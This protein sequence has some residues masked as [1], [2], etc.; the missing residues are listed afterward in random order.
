MQKSVY[1]A[2]QKLCNA[3]R[4]EGVSRILLQNVTGGEGVSRHLLHNINVDNS[5]YH[6]K[7]IIVKIAY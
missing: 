6:R 1:G 5:G 7:H 4:G 3:Y 2:V